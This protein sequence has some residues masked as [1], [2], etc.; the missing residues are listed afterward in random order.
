MNR[1][2]LI[3][4]SE[5]WVDEAIITEAQREQLL[6]RYP[7]KQNKPMLLS[8]AAILIGL[9]F[10]TFVA[11]NWSYLTDIGRLA[12]LLTSLLSFYIIGE[13][14]YR[15]R[16]KRVG[17]SLILIALLVFGSSIFLVGQMYH[18]TTFSA[19]PFFLW[20]LVG[21]GLYMILKETT[22]F[23]ATLIIMTVGQLYSGIVYQDF[24]LWLGLLFILGMGAVVKQTRALPHIMAFS[25]SYVLQAV[26]LVFSEGVPSYWLIAFFL[27]LYV[28]DDFL[29]EKGKRRI[30]KTSSILSIFTMLLLQVFFLGNEYVGE[31]TESSLYF[32]LVWAILFVFAVIRSAMSSTNYYWI[33]L[34]LFVPVFRFEFGDVLSLVILFLYAL[35]WLVSGYQQEVTRWINKGTVAFL[36]TTFVAYFQLA[37]DFM[38]RSLFFFVGGLLLFVLSYF[39][40]KKRRTFHKGGEDK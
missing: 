35:L 12:I 33:D 8:F 14:V 13:W 15:K 10:L 9:G 24:H 39:L 2:Q 7:K 31:L 16:S 25:I 38:N 19:F 22:F 21:F 27:L 26:I 34:L 37:W 17:V 20:S 18:Y 30:F 40:E 29:I 32:F 36:L 28:M 23:H 3:K 5:K 11:S 4:E 6:G 1:D